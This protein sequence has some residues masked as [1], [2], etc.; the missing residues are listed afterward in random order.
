MEHYKNLDL[1][2]I[3]YVCEKTRETLVEQWKPIA[4]Y[5]GLYE[6]SDLGRIKGLE[7]KAWNG[8]S[9]IKIRERILKVF[10][11]KSGYIHVSIY[12][13]KKQKS[14]YVHRLVAES[15]VDN[16]EN[17]PTVNHKNGIKQDNRCFNLEWS[18]YSENNQHSYDFGLKK[19][20]KGELSVKTKFTNEKVLAVRRLYRMRPNLNKAALSRRLGVCE[21]CVSNILSRKRWNHI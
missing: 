17:K 9:F 5:E 16:P 18:T 7:K 8:N 6:V 1:A 10:V 20:P 15:F 14:F 11:N 4:G 12:K 19:R 2:D 3:K 21:S 13:D